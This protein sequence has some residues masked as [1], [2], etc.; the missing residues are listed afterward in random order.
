VIGFQELGLL[1][2][3]LAIFVLRAMIPSV[4]RRAAHAGDKKRSWRD[5]TWTEKAAVGISV[6]LVI[7]AGW[8]R[9]RILAAVAVGLGIATA[10]A[11][12][13]GRAR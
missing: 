10:A 11:A 3:V 6:A 13:R 12:M 8:R 2:I 1:A 4:A 9:P 5:W 7:W